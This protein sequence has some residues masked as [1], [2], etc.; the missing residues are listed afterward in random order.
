M[1]RLDKLEIEIA[2]LDGFTRCLAESL[3]HIAEKVE[4]VEEEIHLLRINESPESS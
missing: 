4:R 1:D 2:K 3:R